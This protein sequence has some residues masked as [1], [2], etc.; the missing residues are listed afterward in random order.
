MFE[1]IQEQSRTFEKI[2]IVPE[3]NVQNFSNITKD[4]D[5]VGGRAS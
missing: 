2:E 1:N 4:R 5:W 3:W